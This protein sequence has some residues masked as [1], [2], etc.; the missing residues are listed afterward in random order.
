MVRFL[1]F[2]QYNEKKFDIF[3]ILFTHA[4]TKDN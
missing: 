3:L 2:A 4:H 1:K